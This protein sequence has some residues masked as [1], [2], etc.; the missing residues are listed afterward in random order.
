MK[1]LRQ[2]KAARFIGSNYLLFVMFGTLVTLFLYSNH[3]HATDLLANTLTGDVK[4]TING[5]GKKWA[6]LIDLGI[7]IGAFIMTK[8]P[9]VFFSVFGVL[10]AISAAGSFVN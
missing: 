6:V 10:L 7:S 1:S 2:S 9:L 4:D 8:K 3:A 5:A